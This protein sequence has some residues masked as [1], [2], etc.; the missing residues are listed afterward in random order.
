M[1]AGHGPV[2]AR[3]SFD[4]HTLEDDP[5]FETVD[6]PRIPPDKQFFKI[7][8]VASITG[9]KPYV[10]RY[11]ESEFAWIRPSKTSSR[12][13]L[14]RRQDVAMV[15]QIKR[16]RYDDHHTIAG[17][18]EVIRQT[19]KPERAKRGIAKPQLRPRGITPISPLA[20][21]PKP[22]AQ[23]GLGFPTASRTAELARRLAE[24]R[25]AVQDLLDVVKE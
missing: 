8:E 10:L 7:G 15:L 19:R 25:R 22:A 9:L 11:W 14:Y 2:D 18:R 4:A 12:Q 24:M 1:R 23:L 17:A 13:R 6:D 20:T 3:D 21:A 16:L 5:R